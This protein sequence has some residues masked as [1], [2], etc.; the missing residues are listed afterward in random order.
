MRNSE[1]ISPKLDNSIVLEKF[2]KSELLSPSVIRYQRWACVCDENLSILVGI[3]PV[4]NVKYVF[5][6]L[7]HS[8]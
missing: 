4:G 6:S 3:V 7:S 1:N 5:P 8:A 2:C